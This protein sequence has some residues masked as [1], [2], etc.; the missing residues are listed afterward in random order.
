MPLY[1]RT[2]SSELDVLVGLFCMRKIIKVILFQQ[3]TAVI[4]AKCCFCN[5]TIF[6]VIVTRNDV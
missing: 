1:R 4:L 5:I 3:H 2:T 6:L